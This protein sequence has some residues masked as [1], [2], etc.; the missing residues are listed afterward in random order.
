M[1]CSHVRK[2]FVE[3]V[4]TWLIIV[5]AQGFAWHILKVYIYTYIYFLK[6]D[7]SDSRQGCTLVRKILFAAHWIFR[8][9]TVLSKYNLIEEFIICI[10][11]RKGTCL[12]FWNEDLKG[13]YIKSLWDQIGSESLNR[14]PGYYPARADSAYTTYDNY[15]NA[16][17]YTRP[18]WTFP[19]K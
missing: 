9:F 14:S 7:Y 18:P 5:I 17:I 3:F 16:G 8:N 13:E 2:I 10:N 6:K 15:W 12:Y 11:I 1:I 19:E 4:Y